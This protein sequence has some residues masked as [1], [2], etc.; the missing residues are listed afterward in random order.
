MKSWAVGVGTL[1]SKVLD[2]GTTGNSRPVSGELAAAPLIDLDL[3]D[4]HPPKRFEGE[5]E[6]SD[7]G[8]E[9][10]E[11]WSSFIRRSVTVLRG[12]PFILR[13]RTRCCSA[14]PPG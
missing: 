14:L 3:T 1:R 4:R 13:L 2:C 8:E 6:S 9:A 11:S 10:E 7:T 5:V 12:P